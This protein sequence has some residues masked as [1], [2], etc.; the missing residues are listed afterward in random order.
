MDEQRVDTGTE[1]SLLAWVQLARAYALLSRRLQT[2]TLAVHG[3]TVPQ[4]EALFFLHA[5][6][7]DALLTQQELSARLLVTKGNVTGLIDRLA[8]RGLVERR[9]D[10][11]DRRLNRLAL[12]AEGRALFTRARPDHDRAVCDLLSALPVA[13]RLH[14]ARLLGRVADSQDEPPGEK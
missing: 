13:D 14:L 11:G 7:D 8:E 4:Y 1:A 10:P 9:A 2:G 5:M 12:T 6:P 3:L